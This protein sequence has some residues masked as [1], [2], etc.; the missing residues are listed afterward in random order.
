MGYSAEQDCCFEQDGFWFR[1]RAA[2]IIIEAGSVLM[3][4]NDIDDYYY[5]IGGGVHLGETSEEAVIREV[6]EET[7][8]T[9]EVER[10]VFVNESMFYGDGS[11]SGKQCHVIE[12]YYLMKPKGSQ[13]LENGDSRGVT[14]EALGGL[15]EYLHWIPIGEFANYKAFPKFFCE[16]LSELPE[17][18]EHFISDER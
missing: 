7:G 17:V 6:K 2:A 4:Y 10:L 8:I 12:F 1:Y 11:L 18:V 9:Y 3:A 14:L 5:S 16:K 15:S 13:L